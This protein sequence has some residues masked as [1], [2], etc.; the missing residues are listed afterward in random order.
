MSI[1]IFIGRLGKI[2]S[3]RLAISFDLEAGFQANKFT[4]QL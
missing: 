3:K 2:A 1:T 4:F